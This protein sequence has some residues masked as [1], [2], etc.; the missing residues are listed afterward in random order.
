MK[1]KH[2]V[3]IIQQTLPHYRE[4]FF[5]LLE[6]N[7][8]RSGISLKLIAGTPE[9]NLAKANESLDTKWIKFIKNK[10][11]KLGS[12]RFYWQS[13][14][15]DLRNADLIIVEQASKFLINYLLLILQRLKFIK[16]GFWGHGKNFK[17][18]KSNRLSEILKKFIS[19]HAHWW[20]AYNERSASVVKSFRYP[21]HRITSVQN[22]IDTSLLIETSS[23]IAP[24][25]LQVLKEKHN[26]RGNNVCL[27]VGAMYREKRLDFL[28]QACISLKKFIPNFEMIFIGSGP[29]SYKVKAVADL[30]PWLHYLGPKY[31]KEKVPFF[32]ISNFLLMPGIVGLAIIDAFSLRTPLVT[33]D[34]IGHGPE[35]FYLKHSYNGIILP[36]RTDPKSYALKVAS[37]LSNEQVLK[38]LK[39]GCL[40]SAKKYTLNSMVDR[41]SN[42]VI[43]ALRAAPIRSDNNKFD[44]K[45]KNAFILNKDHSKSLNNSKAHIKMEIAINS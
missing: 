27:Y 11:F 29:D 30:Y 4:R 22:T 37:L 35:I 31:G 13:C 25:Q 1:S 10:E 20:F 33:I 36:A 8:S 12:T 18:Y 2:T 9:G 44:H 43:E 38:N 16:V 39:N 28:I 3:I 21:E 41:F 19:R 26:V 6:K 34:L 40:I 23:Q 32:M 14:M 5:E 7:L 24:D 45:R 15:K 17:S 42:G